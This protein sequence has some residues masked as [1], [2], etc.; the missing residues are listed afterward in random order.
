[1]KAKARSAL[2]ALSVE[3]LVYAILIAIY[4]LL[5]LHLLGTSLAQI[6][7]EHIRWYSVLCVAL[8][9]GQSIALETITSFLVR[10]LR[11]RAR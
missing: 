6:E 4:F 5:V 2:F 11:R 3:L 8:I 1:M 9:L 10:L 7:T